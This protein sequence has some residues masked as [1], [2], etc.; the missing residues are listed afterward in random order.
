MVGDMTLTNPSKNI[1]VNMPATPVFR[2]L[3]MD[4]TKHGNGIS[5][6]ET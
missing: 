2:F 5:M 4:E 1:W 3:F 6:S